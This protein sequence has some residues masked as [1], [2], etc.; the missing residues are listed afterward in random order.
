[1]TAPDSRRRRGLYVDIDSTL[2][3]SF[4]GVK[5]PPDVLCGKHVGGHTAGRTADDGRL[6]SGAAFPSSVD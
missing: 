4:E 1:M 5:P 2:A 6:H 3:A